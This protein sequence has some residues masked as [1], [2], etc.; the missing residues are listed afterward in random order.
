MTSAVPSSEFLEICDLIRQW[1][2]YMEQSGLPFDLD[3]I[4]NDTLEA[5][6]HPA[7]H[8]EF[9]PF[10]AGRGHAE[11]VRGK[12]ASD[13][14][15][16]LYLHGGGFVAGGAETHR[17]FARLLSEKTGCVFLLLDY[18]LSPEH[19]YPA[20]VEDAESA[21]DVLRSRGAETTGP[22][23]ILGVVGDS[24]GANIGLS[25]LL[26]LRDTGR[27]LPEFAAFLCGLFDLTFQSPSIA[28]NRASD[29]VLKREFLEFCAAAYAGEADRAH[30]E[31]SPVFSRFSQ[32]PPLF[33]QVGGR[34]LLRDDTLRVVEGARRDGV[35]ATLDFWPEMFHSWQ[36]YHPH[37]PEAVE[38]VARLATFVRSQSGGGESV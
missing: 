22:A 13:R 18:R 24:A 29:I 38:A 15:R 16:I 23:E 10:A 36:S 12:G 31:L 33:F 2:D 25:L 37:F 8:P 9:R 26:R 28:E 17:R 11:W 34:E 6:R 5:V 7:N 4:R 3:R 1:N 27:E 20:A 35:A 21:F 32:L 14:R 19:P 30:P